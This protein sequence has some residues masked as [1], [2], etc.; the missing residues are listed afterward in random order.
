MYILF[1]GGNPLLGRKP[2]MGLKTQMNEWN[3][4]YNC[5]CPRSCD[6]VL[7]IFSDDVEAVR[8]VSSGRWWCSYCL[9]GCVKRG[10]VVIDHEAELFQL[11]GSGIFDSTSINVFIGGF[12]MGYWK[13]DST[14]TW[15]P[16]YGEAVVPVW[17]QVLLAAGPAGVS[18]EVFLIADFR[19][20]SEHSFV[21]SIFLLRP[22]FLYAL[23]RPVLISSGLV[24]SHWFWHH[25]FW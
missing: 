14:G 23:S 21:L 2:P 13:S 5:C 3:D 20:R 4:N 24:W 25:W 11:F 16:G 18:A 6:V 12:D 15:H 19:W 8:M 7:S 17:G 22:M 9:C 1:G 10:L